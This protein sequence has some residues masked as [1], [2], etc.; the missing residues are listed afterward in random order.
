MIILNFHIDLWT[1]WGLV[2]QSL[3]L[4]S[5]IYQWYKS[6]QKQ[7]SYLPLGFWYLRL[8]GTTMLLVYVLQRKD[9]VFFVSAILQ[10]VIYIR[11]LYLYKEKKPSTN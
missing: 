11:N 3:F 9:L 1:L 5:F 10:I 2:A 6:E 8:T 7:S 4:F